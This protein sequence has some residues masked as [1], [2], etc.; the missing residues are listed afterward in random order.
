[1]KAEE[2]FEKE[3]Q[4]EAAKERHH[5]TLKGCAL[6]ESMRK[7]V[8]KSDAQQHS[9]NEGK[10]DLHP[11]VR[12]FEEQR[13][14]ATQHRSDGDQE[15]IDKKEGKHVITLRGFKSVKTR[16]TVYRSAAFEA[17]QRASLRAKMSGPAGR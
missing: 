17:W 15:T 1:M 14:K 2:S 7:H 11:K 8:K 6:R 5:D 12:Q 9:R 10:R 3:D 4:K 16:S 13:Q